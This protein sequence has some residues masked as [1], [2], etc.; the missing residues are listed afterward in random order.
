[1]SLAFLIESM[2]T[3]KWRTALAAF[4]IIEYSPPGLP[5]LSAYGYGF[6]GD[7]KVTLWP[8]PL[9]DESRACYPREWCGEEG[10]A[11]VLFDTV[12]LHEAVPLR[13]DGGDASLTGSLP[14]WM[15]YDGKHCGV[16]WPYTGDTSGLQTTIRARA[17][18]CYSD[19]TSPSRKKELAADGESCGEDL[20][21]SF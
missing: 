15:D 5:T 12:L 19:A 2:R 16:R 11:L 10:T 1:V 17:D 3:S 9:R 18:R 21:W 13:K 4:E 14:S 7:G 8:A 20:T 6:R